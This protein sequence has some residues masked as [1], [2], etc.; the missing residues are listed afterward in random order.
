V[1]KNLSHGKRVSRQ[2]YVF[3]A[4]EALVRRVEGK[5]PGN[6]MPLDARQAELLHTF[7]QS[8]V[9]DRMGRSVPTTVSVKWIVLFLPLALTKISFTASP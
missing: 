6:R 9:F 2:G 3:P 1:S 5:R 8:F 7:T 4:H